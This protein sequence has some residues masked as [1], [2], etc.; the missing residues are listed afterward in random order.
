ME[1][2]TLAMKVQNVT[3]VQE[4]VIKFY[5]YLLSKMQ[6]QGAFSQN[7]TISCNSVNC[8]VQFLFGE[9][10][11]IS[12]PP[13]SGKESA[14]TFH[15]HLADLCPAPHHTWPI[16]SAKALQTFSL[17]TSQ[18]H[19]LPNSVHQTYEKELTAITILYVLNSLH[20]FKI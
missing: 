7:K 19:I 17:A 9:T 10:L 1:I 20:A 13:L 11:W 4:V 14:C 16:P 5:R 2:R 6:F 15:A 12:N 18:S 8:K 3:F